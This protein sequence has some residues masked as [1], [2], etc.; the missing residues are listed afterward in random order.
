MTL[1]NAFEEVATDSML[2][3][4]FNLLNLAR[5][6]MDRLRVV[7]D[8]APTTTIANG[9]YQ[10]MYFGASGAVPL[11][12]ANGSS[13]AMDAREQQRALVRANFIETRKRWTFT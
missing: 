13:Q 5:D 2:R 9:S 6:G 12:H 4:L 1:R 7:V 11:W 8:A 3:R 10:N